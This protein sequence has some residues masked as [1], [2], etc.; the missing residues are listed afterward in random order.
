LQALGINTYD[1]VIRL[2]RELDERRAKLAVL[3]PSP[4]SVEIA[5]TSARHA[6]HPSP[7][8]ATLTPEEQQRRQLQLEMQDRYVLLRTYDEKIKPFV[9]QGW[10]KDITTDLNGTAVHRLQ[11]LCWTLALGVV[12]IINVYR[13]LTMPEFNA[14]LLA[15][16]GISC[17]GYV[18]F[19][20]PEVNS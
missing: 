1:D 16:M 13:N 4:A 6:H 17:A 19:K 18:G 12:F 20:Y 9:S 15:L 10:F 7:I 2:R 5:A 8:Q 14:T 3:P 11:V